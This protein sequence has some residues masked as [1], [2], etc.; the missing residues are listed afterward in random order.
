[1]ATETGPTEAMACWRWT[2]LPAGTSTK[3][4]SSAPIARLENRHFLS[5]KVIWGLNWIKFFKYE[6]Y[7]SF[8]GISFFSIN[9]SIVFDVSESVVHESSFTSIVSVPGWAI[10]QVLLTQFNHLSWFPV[11]LSFKCSSLEVR[12][13]LILAKI[14]MGKAEGWYLRYWMTS[15]IH[16][17]LDPSLWKRSHVVSSQHSWEVES[18]A[19]PRKLIHSQVEEYSSWIRS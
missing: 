3:P 10:D 17:V 16:T 11:V 19:G 4:V 12:I 6:T 14:K 1:M 8:I 15:R 9:T 13:L 2:S 7:F 5:Y 18:S